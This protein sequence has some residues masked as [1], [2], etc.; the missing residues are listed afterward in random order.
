MD[1]SNAQ[2]KICYV[3]GAEIRLNALYIG[4]GL[5]RHRSRCAPG[6]DKYLQNPRLARRYGKLCGQEKTG[7]RPFNG[8]TA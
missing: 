4:Q 8:G 6:T 5:Y 7:N 3:C 1:D 2:R